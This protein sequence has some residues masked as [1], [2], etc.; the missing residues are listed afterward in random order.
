MFVGRD[1][2]LGQLGR[3]ERL[4]KA[5]LVVCRGRRRI[6]KSTLI[7]QFG[8]KY[9]QFSEFQG[10][11]PRADISNRHQLDHFSNQLADCFGLPRL[12][13]KDWHEAFALLAHQTA[14][15]K[16]LIF[17]DEISWM[18]SRDSDFVGQLKIA[19]DTKFKK[20]P[21]LML[22]LC[23]SVSSWIDK[24]ILNGADFVGRISLALK[25]QELPL[26][27]CHEFWGSRKS[28]T[29]SLEKFRILALTGGVPRY[30]E[31]VDYK[32]S[33]EQ[34]LTDLCFR[35]SATLLDEF[36]KIFSDIYESS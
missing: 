26:R 10:L 18:A 25:L 3:L 20:N 35:S 15:G 28:R 30:L 4:K 32:A 27:Y 24:N 21:K 2:E 29:S 23:G 16:H 8:R 22:V 6:G 7:Q 5:A 14:K 1:F 13:L 12:S 11:A 17:L 9:G 19:W 34:N 36:D 31:E 33:A